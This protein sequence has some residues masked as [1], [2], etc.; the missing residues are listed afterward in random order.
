MLVRRLVVLVCTLGG[1][2]GVVLG[3]TVVLECRL[4]GILVLGCEDESPG[5]GVLDVR[6]LVLDDKVLKDD[7]LMKSGV[8][9]VVK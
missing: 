6:I 9:F 3:G 2:D 1:E 8:L 7:D 5:F 4:V